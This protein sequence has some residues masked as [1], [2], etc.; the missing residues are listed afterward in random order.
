[1]NLPGIRLPVR[2]PEKRTDLPGWSDPALVQPEIRPGDNQALRLESL[3]DLDLD[4]PEAVAVAAVVLR[5]TNTCSFGRSGRGASHY[6]FDSVGAE[7]EVFK[8][9]DG[10][11]LLELRHGFGHYTVIPPSRVARKD[12]PSI[13]DE[14]VFVSSAEPIRVS[15]GNVRMVAC[16]IATIVLLW[17]HWQK[18]GRHNGLLALAG[19][20]ARVN[21][22]QNLAQLIL[23]EITRHAD[24]QV[25]DECQTSVSN[26]YAKHAAGAKTTGG[27]P[28]G[29]VKWLGVDVVARLNEWFKV[30]DPKSAPRELKLVSADTIEMKPVK[31]LWQ[32]RVP[33]GSF[34]LNAGREGIGKS[35]LSYTLA[36]DLTRGRVEGIFKGQPR[37]VIV[38][39]TEDSWA[40]TITPRLRAA[41]A[42]LS[43]I[44]RV[45]V[46][47]KG[48][49]VELMLPSDVEALTALIAARGD[50]ALVLL[51]PL[52]ARLAS[53]LDTHKD[54][55]VR[56]ALEPISKMADEVG[57]VV[58]GI[59]H[60]NK[61]TSR[62]PLNM[63]MGSRAFAAV[64]RFVIFV[65][66]DPDDEDRRLVGQV[67]NNLGRMDLP[68]LSFT[69]TEQLVATTAAG[70]EIK[71][72]QLVWGADDE[73]SIRDVL[74]EAAAKER[75]KK[76][77]PRGN[78]STWL[79]GYLGEF[80]GAAPKEEVIEAAGKAG[81]SKRTIERAA[82]EL[83]VV[84]KPAGRKTMWSLPEQRALPVQAPAP[85]SSKEVA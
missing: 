15:V 5:D 56:Q 72:G 78:A 37:S 83:G 62:D 28:Q 51:D 32:N 8:D 52:I 39:A 59:I 69:I 71:T 12:D 61:G 66:V 42:D 53:K 73:R 14:L 65:A 43:K 35:M 84:G 41:G 2:Q 24:G 33:L 57:V 27:G 63:V 44:F 46:I 60:V 10:S 4:C 76:E 25:W 22:P 64:A 48:V 45:D 81:H 36:A 77:T 75:E 79:E 58:L 11:I 1:M 9:L 3:T 16:V 6:L 47:T 20:L 68:T 67:K 38:C 26:T 21:V 23:E 82:Q 34:G 7:Y 85:S 49:N 18:S 54:A 31:W 55:E 40:H 80:S 50:V 30:E 29:L 13:I 19:F 17:Q 74:G 70:D